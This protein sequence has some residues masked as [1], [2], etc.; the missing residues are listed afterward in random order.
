MADL[1][2]EEI[3]SLEKRYA[4]PTPTR[5]CHVCG[6]TTWAIGAVG[7]GRITFV[8][9]AAASERPINWDHYGATSHEK[10]CGD[11][12]VISL[13]AEVRRRREEPAVVL[14]EEERGLVRWAMRCVQ[15]TKHCGTQREHHRKEDALR[16]LRL[17]ST[18]SPRTPEGR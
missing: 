13:I 7:G 2:D 5:A 3:A 1:T 8:C 15:E 9:D 12:D 17:L 16:L 18:P 14:T 6:C 4:D 10:I 11:D